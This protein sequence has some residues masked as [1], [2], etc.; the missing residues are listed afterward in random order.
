MNLVT[1]NLIFNTRDLPTVRLLIFAEIIVL[2]NLLFWNQ[3]CPPHDT[4]TF[5][6]LLCRCLWLFF[7]Y[8]TG[9]MDSPGHVLEAWKRE[10]AKYMNILNADTCCHKVMINTPICMIC[11]VMMT[12]ILTIILNSCVANISWRKMAVIGLPRWQSKLCFLQP[13]A[14]IHWSKFL[15]WLSNINRLCLSTSIA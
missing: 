11:S 15:K 2:F 10:K 9:Y 4:T 3:Y 7:C 5:Y 8:V 13:V 12:M 6:Q 14:N 1:E